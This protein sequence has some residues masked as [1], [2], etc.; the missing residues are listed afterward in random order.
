[1]WI[2]RITAL[3]SFEQL[4]EGDSTV[5]VLDE[6]WAHLI[7]NDYVRLVEK[8]PLVTAYASTGIKRT[9]SQSTQDDGSSP[10]S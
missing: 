2:V 9:L 8:W 4:T 10:P 6:R 3:K 7:A 1:M 5:V